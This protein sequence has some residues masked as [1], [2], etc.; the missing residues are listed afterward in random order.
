MAHS[1]E[2]KVSANQE[3]KILWKNPPA[4][5]NSASEKECE[6]KIEKQTQNK[7]A[8]TKGK[9]GDEKWANFNAGIYQQIQYT[10][11]FCAFMCK[12]N[13]A[14]APWWKEAK[15]SPQTQANYTVELMQRELS[16]LLGKSSIWRKTVGVASNKWQWNS[17]FPLTIRQI[18]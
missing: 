12:H 11:I 15:K 10:I 14:A 9:K 13:T 7:K 1:I 18:H 5:Q 8:A 16:L 4:T 17:E 6:K 3:E 2:K